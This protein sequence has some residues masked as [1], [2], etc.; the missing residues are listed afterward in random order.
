MKTIGL[1][2]G[3]Y[4]SEKFGAL[5]EHRTL[6]SLP[7]GGRYR[8]VDFVLSNMVNSGISKVGII[9]PMNSG[10]LNDHVGIGKSWS[11]AQKGEGLYLMPG[12]TYG[13]HSAGS[14]F[15]FRDIIQNKVFL[16]RSTKADYVLISGCTDVY[17]MDYTPF[18]EAHEK[19]GNHITMMYKKIDKNS[20]HKGYFL[21]VDSDNK[22]S[23][24]NRDYN[25]TE[26][27]FCDCFIINK[28]FLVNF[29]EWFKAFEY[30]D[31]IEVIRNNM[32]NIKIGAY[33][34]TGY[35][36]KINTINDYLKV[37]KDMFDYD[38]RNEVFH[39]ERIIYTKVQDEAPALF[40]EGSDAKNAIVATGC[41]VEGK[42]QDS[43]IFR[44]TKIAKNASVN[45]SVL[46]MHC[47]IGEGAVLENVIADKFVKIS[48]GTKIAGTPEAPIVLPKGTVI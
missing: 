10:S 25:S 23:K 35:Y 14:R 28:D 40:L 2:S 27:M 8:L 11:F 30:L 21:D 3:N 46:M 44:S 16:E 48:A 6:A 39:H 13:I 4:V 37:S 9:T 29:I 7:F 12:S 38:I 32:E 17:N 42:V 45:N 36:G 1:I 20:G 26:N 18:I 33:E 15:L 19:S 41:R 34:F 24:I 22:V 31:I 5:N 47:E 43:I